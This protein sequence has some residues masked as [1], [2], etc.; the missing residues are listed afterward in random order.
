MRW[1][2]ARPVSGREFEVTMFVTY[3]VKLARLRGVLLLNGTRDGNSL[4]EAGCLTQRK[5]RSGVP[6]VMPERHA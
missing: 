1:E 5:S 3:R 4:D 6:I 2:S